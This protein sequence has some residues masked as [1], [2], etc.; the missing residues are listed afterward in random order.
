MG[1]PQAP[2]AWIPVGLDDLVDLVFSCFR[3][4]RICRVHPGTNEMNYDL[5]V[6]MVSELP[7]NRTRAPTVVEWSSV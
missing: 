3:I 5:W 1:M 4:I 7:P 6:S 2:V